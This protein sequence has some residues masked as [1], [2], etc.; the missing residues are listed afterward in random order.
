MRI[1]YHDHVDKVLNKFKNVYGRYKV[2]NTNIYLA[3][4]TEIFKQSIISDIN[5]P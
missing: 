2:F 4:I 1:D 3:E 5:N